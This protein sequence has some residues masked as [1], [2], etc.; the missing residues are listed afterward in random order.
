M[1]KYRNIVI[2][3]G[4][5]LMN[6]NNQFGNYFSAFNSKSCKLENVEEIFKNILIGC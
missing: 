4:I 1:M 3:G 5:S 2:T 6:K